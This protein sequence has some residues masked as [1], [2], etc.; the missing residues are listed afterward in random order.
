[1][2]VCG[3][4]TRARKRIA[5]Q[6]LPMEPTPNKKISKLPGKEKTRKDENV[7]FKKKGSKKKTEILSEDIIKFINEGEQISL[8]NYY[9]GFKTG[10]ILAD[11]KFSTK[12]FNVK[13]RF[14][15]SVWTKDK[16]IQFKLLFYLSCSAVHVSNGFLKVLN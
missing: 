8:E 11:E 1:M 12:D 14:G 13:V 3:K 2:E 5:E 16:C 15:K 7:K 6:P 4:S 9:Y 10:Q